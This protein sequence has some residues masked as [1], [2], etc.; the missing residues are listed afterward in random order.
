MIMLGIYCTG[1]VPFE[2]VYLNGLVRDKSGQKISKSKG[3]VINPIEM[4]DKYG[5]DA[6]R[7]GLLMGTAA[8]NDTTV[9]E[10]KIRGYRNFANK[11]WN[12]A[13][14]V[15]MTAGDELS[16]KE[17][18]LAKEDEAMI[19]EF[20][21]ITKDITKD[22]EKLN[23]ARAGETL[24][25]Y[26]WHHF[27]DICIEKLKAKLQDPE[28]E[29]SAKATL[30]YLLKNSLIMLHPFVPFVSEAV[31]QAMYAKSGLLLSQKW[32]VL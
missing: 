6:L 30:H 24:Y 8:G 20:D 7:M 2:T 9:S 22:L 16:I 4:I 3:N 28:T 11:V 15:Q 10:E 21:K 32:F 13:R 26:F 12:A 5:A 18:K 29:K 23:L 1:K 27:C 25:E 17:I 31:W 14:F 19:N